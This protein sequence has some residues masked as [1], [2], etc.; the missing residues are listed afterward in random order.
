MENFVNVFSLAVVSAQLGIPIPMPTISLDDDDG[1]DPDCLLLPPPAP[2]P[3]GQEPLPIADSTGCDLDLDDDMSIDDSDD[4][5]DDVT[6]NSSLQESSLSSVST[7]PLFPQ[8]TS[9]SS[10]G[11]GN[12]L[13]I[14]RGDYSTLG[15]QDRFKHF[16]QMPHGQLALKATKTSIISDKRQTKY[17][18]AKKAI[19][20]FKGQAKQMQKQL[21]ILQQ[22]VDD[23]AANHKFEIVQIGKKLTGKAAR[24]SQESLI[25][26]GLRRSLSNISAGD[27]GLVVMSDISKNTVLRAE[28]AAG[29]AMVTCMQAFAWE[30]Y[31]TCGRPVDDSILHS[32][33]SLPLCDRPWS[34]CSV[35]Y[36]CDATHSNIH[37]RKKLHVLE[38][39]AAYISD[40]GKWRAGLF[41]EAVSMR[42]CM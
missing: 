21:V 31:Q 6:Q 38:A 42:Q 12:S 29:S 25:A 35:S 19:R 5:G 36:T 18:E 40:H 2:A 8:R 34:L 41:R 14:I 13:N 23:Q 4:N 26:V 1:D 27:F 37:K 28:V 22:E 15:E 24:Y 30:M 3:L 39:S 17:Q 11:S 16:M 7:T 20:Q 10:S 9:S 32:S 33:L